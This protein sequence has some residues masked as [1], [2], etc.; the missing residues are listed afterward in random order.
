MAEIRTR[1]GGLGKSHGLVDSRHMRPEKFGDKNEGPEQWKA[2]ST[3]LAR[4]AGNQDIKYKEDMIAAALQKSSEDKVMTDQLGGARYKIS[5]EQDMELQSLLIECCLGKALSL[6]LVIEKDHGT[7]LEMWRKLENEYNPDTMNRTLAEGRKLLNPGAGK[8][9]TE[10]GK[11]LLEWDTTLS[12]KRM[13]D[14]SDGIDESMKLSILYGMLPPDKAKTIWESGQYRTVDKMRRHMEDMVRNL[15][16]GVAPMHIGNIAEADT[17]DYLDD[18][19][20]LCR[21]ERDSGG[22]WKKVQG[23]RPGRDAAAPKKCFQCGETG[24]LKA[25]CPKADSTC[26][27][28]GR[29]GHDAKKCWATF[30]VDRTKIAGEPPVKKPERGVANLE[31]DQE[32][33]DDDSTELGFLIDMCPLEVI[34]KDPWDIQDPWGGLGQQPKQKIEDASKEASR[35]EDHECS[36]CRAAGIDPSLAL[37]P[38]ID[39]CCRNT[40]GAKGE[41][42]Q[43]LE[44]VAEI[45]DVQAASCDDDDS[46]VEPPKE[47][48]VSRSRKKKMK[49][50]AKNIRRRKLQET[51]KVVKIHEKNDQLEV[52]PPAARNTSLASALE[53][54]GLPSMGELTP[55]QEVQVGTQAE[56]GQAD[57]DVV[58]I[59]GIEDED[60]H[61]G[62]D[63]QVAK[64][65]WCMP[66]A[67]L[68]KGLLGDRPSVEPDTDPEDALIDLMVLGDRME[69]DQVED[70]GRMDVTVDSGAGESVAN[71]LSMP[72]YPVAPSAG[73]LRGQKYKGPAGEIIPNQGQQR[74]GVTIESGSKRAMTFQSAPVR[75]PLLAVSGACDR[76]QFV[77]FDNDGSFICRRDTPEAMAILK[78]IKQIPSQDKIALHRKNGTYSMPVWLQ[79]FQRQGK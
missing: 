3:K 36:I 31:G 43:P 30:H 62:A 51:A 41:T 50:K 28:C 6:V 2:W 14:G 76:D 39:W 47:M 54:L 44:N 23:K 15:T 59:S 79:P 61:H 74:I 11:I 55:C 77:F 63:D 7:G 46:D 72:Q 16:T 32:E 45:A 27:R 13:R 21:L 17:L 12:E 69:V 60:A 4:Y 22:R 71:P 48:H 78:L 67:G 25:N 52:L 42:K 29:K 9:W 20:E 24:H 1:P 64:G 66:G 18:Q 73:S 34:D 26:R 70:G 37:V 56:S 19:G 33:E 5:Q 38:A 58:A 65:W 8:N 75:K 57:L 35:A 68:I 10:V 53:A 49:T 40:P